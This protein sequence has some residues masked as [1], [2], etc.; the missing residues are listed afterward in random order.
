[1][2]GVV[3]GDNVCGGGV[4]VVTVWDARVRVCEGMDLVALFPVAL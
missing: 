1:M 3:V 4:A 2:V